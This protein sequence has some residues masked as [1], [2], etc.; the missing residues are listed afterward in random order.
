M[1]IY[2][3]GTTGDLTLVTNWVGGANPGGTDDVV[4]PASAAGGMSSN[5]AGLADTT[6]SWYIHPRYEHNIGSSGAPLQISAADGFI[7][8]SP[9]TIYFKDDGTTTTYVEANKEGGTLYIDG[10][11]V[12][13]IYVVKGNVV[14]QSSIGNITSLT[15]GREANVTIE[16]NGNTLTTCYMLGGNG[17]LKS[18]MAITTM[19]MNG[20]NFEQDNSN[21]A[22]TTLRQYG[23]TTKYNSTAALV[24]AFIY[25]GMLDL[26]DDAQAKT[27][28]TLWQWPGATVTEVGPDD[29]ISDVI[30]TISN[31]RR[32]LSSAGTTAN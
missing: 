4:V 20:G 7:D 3:I 11:T 27:V 16:G 17:R 22:V 13:D 24:T 8:H 1:A 29:G 5:M 6:G 19:H 30:T 21:V 18:G 12:T 23:G 2:W 14:I 31:R 10:D 15:V 9:A 26:T 25:G 28:T 32:L